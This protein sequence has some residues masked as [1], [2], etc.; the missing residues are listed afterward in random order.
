MSPMIMKTKLV[1]ALPENQGQRKSSTEFE[2]FVCDN[3]RLK[4]LESSVTVREKTVEVWINVTTY[5][6]LGIDKK[7]DIFLELLGGESV[8]ATGMLGP[9]Q[10]EEGKRG[11]RWTTIKVPL[12]QWP[13]AEVPGL[14]M[15]MNVVDDP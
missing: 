4:V 2:S 3:V 1:S 9:F 7:V 8:L 15:T 14:R 10:S 11:R 13:T 5:T 12:E 6:E